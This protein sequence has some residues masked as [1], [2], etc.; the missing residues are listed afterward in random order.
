M[1]AVSHIIKHVRVFGDDVREGEEKGDGEGGKRR[2]EKKI[3]GIGCAWE[4]SW[5]IMKDGSIY[6]FGQRYD[7]EFQQVKYSEESGPI[8][9]A[10]WKV[11]L[12]RNLKE[13]GWRKIFSW[14]FL[15]AG[16]AGSAFSVLLVEDVFHMVGLL[17]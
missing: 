10:P 13:E 1:K 4:S 8:Q 16:N 17:M 15:G 6:I 7:F 3:V 2:E 14:E 9:K 11:K 5:V 12:P